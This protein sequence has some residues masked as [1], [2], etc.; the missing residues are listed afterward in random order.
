MGVGPAGQRI[1]APSK[2][3]VEA[4]ERARLQLGRRRWAMPGATQNVVFNITGQGVTDAMAVGSQLKAF[5]K[6]HFIEYD[7]LYLQEGDKLMN[8][9]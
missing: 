4:F 2:P 1:S 9:F 5:L 8:V 7:H 3:T 6:E